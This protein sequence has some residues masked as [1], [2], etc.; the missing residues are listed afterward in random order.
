MEGP[1]TALV[2]TRVRAWLALECDMGRVPHDVGFQVGVGFMMPGLLLPLPLFFAEVTARVPGQEL[3][4]IIL[5]TCGWW[6]LDGVFCHCRCDF[7]LWL[8]SLSLPP[9]SRA[10]WSQATPFVTWCGV[11]VWRTM[12]E[13]SESGRPTGDPVPLAE[14]ATLRRQAGDR[15][16]LG[17]PAASPPAWAWTQSC[18]DLVVSAP[19]LLTVPEWAGRRTC[20]P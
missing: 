12:N 14:G 6:P 3:P 5:S 7:C 10:G 13:L 18:D 4:E 9:T 16:V 2:Q 17:V 1:G 15:G 11:D 19:L 20:L 8:E